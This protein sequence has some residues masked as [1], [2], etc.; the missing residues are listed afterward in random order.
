MKF[1]GFIGDDAKP[2][3]YKVNVEGSVSGDPEENKA[4]FTWTMVI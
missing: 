4:T 3:I 1:S 2:G